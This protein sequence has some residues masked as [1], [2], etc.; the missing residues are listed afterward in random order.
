[1]IWSYDHKTIA[2]MGQI[3][4]IRGCLSEH[5]G[6]EP[7]CITHILVLTLSEIETTLNAHIYIYIY[8]CIYVLQNIMYMYS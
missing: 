6:G 2:K 4:Y 7:K 5:H 3:L 1:M 8:I